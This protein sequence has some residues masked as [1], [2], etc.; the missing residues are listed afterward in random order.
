[1]KKTLALLLALL[2]LASVALVACNDDGKTPVNDDDYE[3]GD[4]VKDDEDDKDTED[5][6]TDDKDTEKDGNEDEDTEKDTEKDTEA[7]N[8][9]DWETKNDTVYTGMNTVNLRRDASKNSAVGKEVA[10]FATPLERTKTNGIWSEVK[11]EGATYYVLNAMI[12]TDI[13]DF[14]FEDQTTPATITINDGYQVCFYTTPF[15]STGD[16]AYNNVLKASGVKADYLSEGSTIKKIAT[17][18]NGDW[19]KIE[20]IGKIEFTSGTV[21]HTAENPGIYYLADY[22]VTKGYVTDSDRPSS[23]SQGGPSGNG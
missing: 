16:Y 23:G 5:K 14:E 8:K 1:M 13:K 6:D 4:N 12:S 7:D 3:D 17:S 18:K 22:T 21:E 20:F 10:N 19:M 2:M 9:N 15:E 11:Y